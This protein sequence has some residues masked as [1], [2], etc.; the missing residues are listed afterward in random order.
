M[1]L[2]LHHDPKDFEARELAARK[3][4]ERFKASQA[5]QMVA[6]INAGE[7][8]MVGLSERPPHD[9]FKFYRGKRHG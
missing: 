4:H 7:S 1:G 3:R 9:V 5:G 2:D 8:R 6:S